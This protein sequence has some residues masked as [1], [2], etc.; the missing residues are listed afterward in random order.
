VQDRRDVPGFGPWTTKDGVA[1]VQPPV[2]I[3]RTMLAVRLHLDTSGPDNGPLRVLAGTHGSGR[4]GATEITAASKARAV[5]C[6]VPQGG[7]LVLRP[8]LLHASSACQ[9]ARPRRVI[10]LEFAVSGLPAGLE[11]QDQLEI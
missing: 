4:L 10:H 2:E 7:A 1:H 11:W 8:L 6:V 5:T 9:E 3:L